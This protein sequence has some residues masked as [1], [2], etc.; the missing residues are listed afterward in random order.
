MK[1][2]STIDY[3]D[4][5]RQIWE[6]ELSEFVPDR[7]LDAHIHFF[8]ASDFPVPPPPRGARRCRFVHAERLARV[9]YPGRRMQYLILGMP[10]VGIDVARHVESVRREIDGVP[11]I[12]YNRL[13]TPSCRI[14]DIERDLRHPQFIGAETV[15]HLFGDPETSPSAGSTS[16]CPTNRWSWRTITV[17]GSPCTCRV[18]TAAPTSGIWTT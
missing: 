9:L 14:E 17:S 10:V 18:F 3:R 5:D 11:G 8:W 13:V 1:D 4:C 16:S 15:P 7:I 6:E 2:H 12:R